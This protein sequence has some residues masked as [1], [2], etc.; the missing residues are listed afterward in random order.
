MLILIKALILE[1]M[2]FNDQ[3]MK[4]SHSPLK[5]ILKVLLH[6]SPLSFMAGENNKFEMYQS[7]N[8]T[9]A[10]SLPYYTPPEH[11]LL[12]AFICMSPERY[13]ISSAVQ[14][15]TVV[16]FYPNLSLKSMWQADVLFCCT[17][18]RSV[19]CSTCSHLPG[20]GK[21]ANLTSHVAVQRSWKIKKGYSPITIVLEVVIC[22]DTQPSWPS[23]LQI[24]QIQLL[25]LSSSS[26]IWI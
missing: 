18:F 7:S 19:I 21:L 13:Y 5:L 16:N 23:T 8:C 9:W 11:T 10:I 24:W 4:P 1:V 2:P 26:A 12:S 14:T 3:I 20:K 6:Y 25:G 15:R 22:T 17:I